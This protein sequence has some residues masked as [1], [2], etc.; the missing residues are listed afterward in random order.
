MRAVIVIATAA[1]IACAVV[2][3]YAEQ[4]AASN[5]TTTT[6]ASHTDATPGP[7]ASPSRTVVVAPSR[8]G[9]FRVHARINGRPVDF[10]V[11][12]G[13]TI[14]ALTER[15]AAMLGIRPDARDYSGVVR[16]ANGIA[17]V[18]RVVLSTVEIDDLLV[19]NV[20]AVVSPPG[21]LNENLLGL[22]FL[23]RLQRFEYANGKLVLEQ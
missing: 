19:H 11:D 7:S 18:A 1:L 13:A 22:S 10:L 9:H 17:R 14:I 2:P 20:A 12:T 6:L 21:A 3:R 8:D 4:L 23:S 15:D 16:T 5:A